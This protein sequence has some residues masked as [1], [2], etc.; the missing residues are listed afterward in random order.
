MGGR[1]H[2]HFKTSRRSLIAEIRR[3]GAVSRQGRVL[4]A[5]TRELSDKCEHDRGRKGNSGSGGS[6]GGETERWRRGASAFRRGARFVGIRKSRPIRCRGRLSQ[7]PSPC[8][9]GGSEA[10]T[11]V[12][13]ESATLFLA[14]VDSRGFPQLLS[15]PTNGEGRRSNR[16]PGVRDQAADQGSDRK[17]PVSVGIRASQRSFGP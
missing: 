11:Q 8:L 17:L 1:G 15:H 6:K 4:S 9:L 13:H 16:Q 7:R 14:L 12:L 5:T 2:A 3:L 10:A